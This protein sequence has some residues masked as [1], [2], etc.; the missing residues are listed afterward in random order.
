MNEEVRSRVA[1]TEELRL[2]IPNGQLVLAYQPQ[3]RA[4]SGRIVGVEALIRWRHPRRGIFCPVIF[5]R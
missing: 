1:L 3:V 5:C 2:A 4:K